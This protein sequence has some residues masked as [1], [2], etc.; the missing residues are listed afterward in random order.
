MAQDAAVGVD[1]LC[2]RGFTVR[3]P[4]STLTDTHISKGN[5]VLHCFAPGVRRDTKVNR[6][7]C[8][9]PNTREKA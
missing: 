8:E 3:L 1:D 6:F 5:G 7:I 4:L 9:P 2:H